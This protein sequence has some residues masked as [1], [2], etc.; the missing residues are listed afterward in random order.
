MKALLG[1][2]ALVL[3]GACSSEPTAP[4][5]PSGDDWT[6]WVCDSQTEVLWRF[7]DPV[8]AGAHLVDADRIKPDTPVELLASWQELSGSVPAHNTDHAKRLVMEQQVMLERAALPGG[9]LLRAVA[10][11]SWPLDVE[12]TTYETPAPVLKIG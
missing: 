12:P 6:R 4:A 8:K 2:P 11:R 5:E 7:A 9:I 3:L 1:L 10:R